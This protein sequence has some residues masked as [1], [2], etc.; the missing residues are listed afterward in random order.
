MFSISSA[1]AIILL[2]PEVVNS[3]M[4]GRSYLKGTTI[5]MTRLP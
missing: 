4:T 1:A 2:D 3:G 5:A